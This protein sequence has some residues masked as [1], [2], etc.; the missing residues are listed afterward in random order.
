MAKSLNKIHLIGNLGKDPEMRTT[1]SG[2]K[3]VTI[4]LCTNDGW[5]DREKA[6]W[7]RITLWEK[8]AEIVNDYAKKGDRV[9]VEGHLEY[10]SYEKDG[11]TIPTAEIIGRELLLLGGN[12]KRESAPRQQAAR[13]EPPRDLSEPDDDL[14]F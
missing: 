2:K 14:P 7:H 4:S 12:E 13:S 11:V 8:L 6:N 1:Q 3:V 5:G 10:G 9:Y